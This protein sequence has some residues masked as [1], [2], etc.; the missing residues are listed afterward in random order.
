MELYEDGKIFCGNRKCE[1]ECGRS[2][3]HI[4]YGVLYLR[5]YYILDKNGECKYR[6]L[7]DKKED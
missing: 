4:P 3:S 7:I 5:E 1:L 6:E 2:D